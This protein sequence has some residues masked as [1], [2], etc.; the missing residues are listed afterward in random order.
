MARPISR[1]QFV[2]ELRLV[3]NWGNPNRYILAET[4]HIEPGVLVRVYVGNIDP[5]LTGDYAWFRRDLVFQFLASNAQTLHKWQL[6]LAELES[7]NL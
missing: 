5:L 6:L 1:S 2:L 3:D 7:S 4:A